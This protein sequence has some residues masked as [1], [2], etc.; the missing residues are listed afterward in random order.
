MGRP[1]LTPLFLTLAILLVEPC[2]SGHAAFFA[3]PGR[4]ILK[5]NLPQAIEYALTHNRGLRRAANQ[6][7]RRGF[8]VDSTNSEFDVKL[9]PL[10][11]A[12]V[13][14][15]TRRISAGVKL[16]K[17]FAN[18]VEASLAPEIGRIDD[19]F[20]Q[21]LSASLKI[22]L[23]K[24]YGRETNLDPVERARFGFRTAQ[25]SLYL[26]RVNTVIE[27]VAAIYNATKSRR[28]TEL[29][30]FMAGRLSHHLQDA[31]L[32]RQ[33]G[34]ATP[35]DVFRVKIRLKDVQDNLA[36]SQ[37][38]LKNATDRLKLLLAVPM[39]Q[40]LTVTAP[41][42]LPTVDMPLE[43]AFAIGLARR[44]E[45]QQA[46]DALAESRRRSQ[47]AGH[48]LL[49]GVNIVAGFVSAGSA[50]VFNDIFQPQEDR[51][52]I[53]LEGNTDWA[54][55]AEK[56]AF[57]QSL[58]DIGSAR[59]D[60]ASRREAV[61]REIRQELDALHRART[62]IRIRQAQIKQARGKLALAKIKFHYNM[63]DNFD[64]MEADRE[65]QQ[66]KVNLLNV[67]TDYIV[68]TF[69]LRR[70]LGTLLER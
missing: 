58:L 64:V 2:T 56:A 6:L 53:S 24:G 47:V 32:R 37:T 17:Q 46:Q 66:A 42:T 26:A 31:L 50:A 39:E 43:K 65:W 3:K 15:E 30:E 34:L 41:L 1:Y 23:F 33:V 68:G 55:T 11:Q 5:L 18:G 14:D 38:A 22:P 60:L 57:Q 44:V 67:K 29:F 7:K 20:R 8:S 27:T 36:V 54:R 16:S 13:S 40:P 51:W 28:L 25:R 19:A 12:G 63:A 35:L 49:P 70:V 52:T 69:R 48:N 21:E 61:K 59:L 10:S 45:I 62:R 9:R 4:R